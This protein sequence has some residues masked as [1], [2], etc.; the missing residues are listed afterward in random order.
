MLQIFTTPHPSK[1]IAMALISFNKYSLFLFFILTIFP[2][3]SILTG[4]PLDPLTPEELTLVKTLIKNSYP[5]TSS[6]SFHYVTLDEPPKQYSTDEH[7]PSSRRAQAIIRVDLQTHELILDLSSRKL[8]SKQVYH[9]IGFPTLTVDET[10]AAQ[11]LPLSYGPFVSSVKRRGLN[12]SEVVCSVTT[13]GWFGEKDNVGKRRAVK[14]VCFSMKDTVSIYLFPIQGVKMVVDLDVMKVVEFSDREIVPLPKVDEA[15]A[16]Y[17][18]SELKP[19]FGPRI[20]GATIVQDN[21]PG[22]TVDGHIVRWM[23]WE[24]HVAF[25][26]RP[27]LVIS[28]ARIYDPEKHGFRSVLYRGHISE[29][30]VPYQDPSEDYYFRTFFDCGEFGFGLSAVSLLPHGD[31]PSNAVFMDGYYAS[32]DGTPVKVPNV[33]CI[34]ERH[35]GQVMWRHTESQIPHKLVNEVR[36]DVSLVIRMVATVGNYDHI[37]D[38]EFKPSGSIKIQVGLSGILQ[39]KPVNYSNSAHITEEAHGT[40]IA[41]N[42]IGLYHDHFLSFHLDLDIDGTSNSFIKK[43]LVTKRVT[44]GETPRKSY[45]T[46]DSETAKTESDAKIRLG[47]DRVEMS[48]E[49]PDEMTKLGNPHGYKLIPGSVI[50]PL[51][52]QDD[53]PQL[54]G[55]FTNYNVWVTPYNKT[56]KYAGGK[57]VD[58]SHGTDGLAAWTKKNREIENRDIVLWYVMGFHHLPCQED[59]PVMPTVSD[60]FELRPANF[61]ERNPVIKAVPP[62]SVRVSG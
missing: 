44:N 57:Y 19:P 45:W 13:K 33:F 27:G 22:F 28:Q 21:S 7:K 31:C 25:D 60:G 11:E 52:T 35:A 12:V 37:V 43:N 17:R 51:L 61:F 54:R 26:A 53:Y 55:A 38:W 16:E 30:F 6:L 41:S 10:K 39:V 47:S 1:R 24:L 29:L 34:F 40:L 14:L 8:A 5:P 3:I 46:V 36:P 32:S 50:H 18:L 15:A 2:T 56:E 4:H 42:T 58:Q 49:N 20:N 48:I 23:N 59:Y 62:R 9:G